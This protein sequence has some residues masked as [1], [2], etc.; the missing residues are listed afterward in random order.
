[1]NSRTIRF[2]WKLYGKEYPEYFAPY[3]TVILNEL[4]NVKNN[5]ENN[6]QSNFISDYLD[7]EHE[8]MNNPMIFGEELLSDYLCDI[9]SVVEMR[10]YVKK[11][12][13]ANNENLYSHVVNSIFTYDIILQKKID[14]VKLNLSILINGMLDTSENELEDLIIKYLEYIQIVLDDKFIAL[15]ELYRV[16]DLIIE[17]AGFENNQNLI[18]NI[19]YINNWIDTLQALDQTLTKERRNDIKR[20]IQNKANKIPAVLG[21]VYNLRFKIMKIIL[22]R[23]WYSRWHILNIAISQRL[24]HYERHELIQKMIQDVIDEQNNMVDLDELFKSPPSIS[25]HISKMESY[26][27]K[28]ISILDDYGKTIVGHKLMSKYTSG[29]GCFAIMEVVGKDNYFSL[30]SQDDYLGSTH[31]GFLTLKCNIESLAYSINRDVFQGKFRWAPLSD[32][33]KRYT[34]LIKSEEDKNK[35]IG[36]PI[37]LSSD[38]EPLNANIV[39]STYGCCERK[40]LAACNNDKLDKII[41]SRWAPCEKCMPALYE[42]KGNVRIF[43]LFEKPKDRIDNNSDVKEYIIT[44]SY[45]CSLK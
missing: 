36:T 35:Y 44:K 15:Q 18:E 28:N 14:I 42:E 41:Y 11:S 23:R 4:F 9:H 20:L 21:E 12:D 33:T 25:Y 8:A 40:M 19:E 13:L 6:Y 39:G 38:T 10:K 31:S 37:T 29:K 34:I 22:H 3:N 7:S 5:N 30:S 24:F 26:I 17:S 27:N 45:S 43:A 16:S 2:D 1:M 32:D